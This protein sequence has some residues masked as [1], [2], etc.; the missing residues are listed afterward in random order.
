MRKRSFAFLHVGNRWINMAMVSDIEDHGSE[1][2]IF[3]TSEMAR[4]AGRGE[5]E[6]IDVARRFTIEDPEDVE[7][8]RRWLML[9]DED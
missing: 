9:N 8:V 4:L 3:L 5:P 1:L 7:K 6:P 2:T